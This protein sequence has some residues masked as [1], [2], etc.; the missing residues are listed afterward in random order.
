MIP[1]LNIIILESINERNIPILTLLK[2]IFF[3]FFLGANRLVI[4]LFTKRTK[5]NVKNF[6]LKVWPTGDLQKSILC[7]NGMFPT[8]NIYTV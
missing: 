3:C 7:E 2:K 1:K 6:Q 5:N 8:E 4:S